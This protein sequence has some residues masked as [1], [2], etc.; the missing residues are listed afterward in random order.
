M[1]TQITSEQIEFYREN[2]FLVIDDFLNGSELSSWQ[3]A[4]D[5][6]VAQHVSRPDAFHNQKGKDNYYQNVFVQCVNLWKTSEKVKQ[7]ILDPELG[8]LAADLAGT[9]GVRLYHDHAMVK[10]SWANPT[11]FHVDNPYDP[12]LFRSGD[13]VLGG[14]RRYNASERVSV[15][16]ARHTQD[17]QL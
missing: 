13:Y 5:E 9:S 14:T 4:V 11:N 12:F 15:F 10:Q 2:G 3:D 17:E 8:R 6:A 1:N 16:S 7:L